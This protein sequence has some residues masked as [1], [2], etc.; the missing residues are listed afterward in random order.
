MLGRART[1]F[2]L[3]EYIVLKQS[4]FLP[5]PLLAP[6]HA[7]GTYLLHNSWRTET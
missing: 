6:V 5:N 4:L 3:Q 1:S 7:H 2:Q